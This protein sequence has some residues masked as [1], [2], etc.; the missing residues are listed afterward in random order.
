ML[1]QRGVECHAI[2]AS[3]VFN[4]LQITQQV[5]VLHITSFRVL[6]L[7]TIKKDHVAIN[8][9]AVSQDVV[10]NIYFCYH[11]EGCKMSKVDGWMDGL[12]SLGSAPTVGVPSTGGG[13][14]ERRYMG[15]S[16]KSYPRKY[17]SLHISS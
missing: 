4:D 8:T 2:Q 6:V 5:T 14:S 3:W 1:F 15:Q 11:K 9:A 12:P 7:G 17:H 13:T 10:Q 16:L